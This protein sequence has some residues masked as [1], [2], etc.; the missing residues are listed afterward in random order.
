MVKYILGIRQNAY[1]FLKNVKVPDTA[2]PSR[3]SAAVWFS[4]PGLKYHLPGSHTHQ[5]TGET[6][7]DATCRNQQ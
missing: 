6:L 3:P 4:L 1:E 7:R 2:E 5:C